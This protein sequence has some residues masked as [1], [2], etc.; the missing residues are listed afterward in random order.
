MHLVDRR[1]R[2]KPPLENEMDQANEAE[3]LERSEKLALSVGMAS[4][5]SA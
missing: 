3:L 4:E 2:V 1:G 5:G